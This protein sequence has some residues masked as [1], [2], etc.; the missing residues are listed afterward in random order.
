MH[1]A[2]VISVSSASAAA[3]VSWWKTAIHFPP[4]LVHTVEEMA[5]GGKGCPWNVP[6]PVHV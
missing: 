3:A 1:P 5:F 6:A 2:S 4:F